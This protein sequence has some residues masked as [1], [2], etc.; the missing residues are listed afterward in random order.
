L[1]SL[2]LL[3]LALSVQYSFKAMANRSA[4]LRWREQLL[5]LAEEDIYERHNYPN[6]PIMALLLRPLVELPPVVGALA[7][8]YLK[9]GMALLAIHWAIRLV[10]NP[11]RPFPGWAKALAILL[12]LRPIMGDLMHGNV[13]LFILFLVLAALYAFH[14]GRD[15]SAG[16]ILALSIACKVTHALFVP[17]FLWKRAWKTLAGCAAGLMLFLFV[18]PGLVLGNSR[19]LQLLD[20]WVERMITPYVVEGTVM[21][22]HA[23]QS[24]PGLAFRLSTHSPSFLDQE[25][26]PLYYHNLAALDPAPVGWFLKACMALFAGLVVWSCRTPPRP[27]HGWRWA[28]EFSVVLLG[29]LLFSERTW[30]HHCVTL[31]LPFTVLSYYLAAC[32]PAR[33]LRGYLI[34]TLAAVFLLMA[35]TS[36]SLLDALDGAAKLAQVYGAYVWAYLLLVAALVTLLRRD[37]SPVWAGN[38]LAVPPGPSPPSLEQRA[39]LRLPPRRAG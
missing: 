39:P 6:P 12:T 35:S 19:N 32:R 36:T 23:N 25:Y 21:S 20:S 34:A 22:T 2:L 30:K 28:A 18:V 31:L 17:Y 15:V 10:D 27:R 7:W 33:P 14:C 5:L 3:F 26:K 1:L 37:P 8:F 38:R 4:I 16:L 11:E 24:L 29:M 13:N 9:V